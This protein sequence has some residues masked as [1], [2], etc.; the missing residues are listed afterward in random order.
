MGS[1]QIRTWRGENE[2]TGE[3]ENGRWFEERRSLIELIPIR[4]ELVGNYGIVGLWT[5]DAWPLV[6]R[7][8]NYRF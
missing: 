5:L 2:K 1:S 7:H 4:I 6:Q 8:L 3:E